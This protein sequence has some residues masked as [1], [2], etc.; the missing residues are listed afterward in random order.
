MK[1]QQWKKTW[2]EAFLL[3]KI[4][5]SKSFSSESLGHDEN[6]DAVSPVA[7]PDRV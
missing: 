7:V 6:P 4:N 3:A 1:S 5:D 2:K